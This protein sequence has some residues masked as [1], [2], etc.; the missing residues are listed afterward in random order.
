[1]V[2]DFF[3]GRGQMW[4]DAEGRPISAIE[5]IVHRA[6]NSSLTTKPTRR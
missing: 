1:L 3:E 4:L 5:H 6:G 2:V